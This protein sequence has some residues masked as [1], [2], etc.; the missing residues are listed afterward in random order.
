VRAG[1][2]PY[3]TTK[4]SG[5]EWLGAV[6]ENWTISPLGRLG[7]LFKGNGSNK[8]DE[9]STGVPCIRYGD[10][11]TQHEFF[12]RRS[13]SFVTPERSRRYTQIRRGDVLFAASG[14]T[15]EDI[16]RSAA[17]LIEETAC[18][19][20]DIIIFRPDRRLLPEFLGYA[21]DSSASK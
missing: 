11:Y 10:L 18:C 12:V 16:G 3:P 15:I 14:E 4:D 5:A 19:G 21:C 6:P 17:N 7:E 20:G 1:A 9:V 8:S 2:K 13:R